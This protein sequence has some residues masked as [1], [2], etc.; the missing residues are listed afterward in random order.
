MALGTGKTFQ[1]RLS[2]PDST[3]RGPQPTGSPSN[4]GSC[5]RLKLLL[6]LCCN[7]L[8]RDEGWGRSNQKYFPVGFFLLLSLSDLCCQF[9]TSEASSTCVLGSSSVLL[10]YE[11]PFAL[12]LWLAYTCWLHRPGLAPGLLPWPGDTPYQQVPY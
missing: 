1:Q 4:K 8:A 7:C 9:A 5:Y 2:A 10:L 6:V 11:A 3:G 12:Q